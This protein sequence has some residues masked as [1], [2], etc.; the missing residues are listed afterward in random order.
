MLGETGKV[1]A[2][3][4]GGRKSAT[5]ARSFAHRM[6]RVTA[7]TIM[8]VGI[9]A[10]SS[11]PVAA[12]AA[13]VPTKPASAANASSPKPATSKPSG[14]GIKPTEVV[15]GR[16]VE[17]AATGQPLVIKRTEA[18]IAH[19]KAFDAATAQIRAI[20]VSTE[21]GALIKA[22]IKSIDD[23]ELSNLPDTVAQIRDPAAKKLVEWYRLR[24]GWGQ[25]AEYQPFL[26]AN[27]AWPDRNILNQ[28]LEEL[29]FSEGGSAASIKARFE[30]SEPRT[31][32]GHAALA[33]ADLA[34]GETSNARN[35]AVRVWRDMTVPAGFEIPFLERFGGVLTEAD[36]QWRLDRLLVDDIRAAKDRA[37]RIPAIRRQ[38][39]RLKDEDARR[40]AEARLLVFNKA[41]IDDAKF[42][43]RKALE[44]APKSDYGFLY[45]RIQLLRRQD[46]FDDAIK[47]I[48]RAP[49]DP[50][51]V[52]NLDD[53]W[54]E[55]RIL[56]YSALND[57]N[58]KLAYALVKDAGP[59]SVNPAK[60][61]AFMAGWLA[62]R[63]LNDRKAAKGHFEAAL[64]AA[65]G[66]L[67][68]GRAGY[69]LGR[70]AESEGGMPAASE[71]YQRAAKEIDTFYGQLSRLKLEPQNRRI[72]IKLPAPPTPEQIA[73]FNGLDAVRAIQI[74][75]K[76]GLDAVVIRS[77]LTH[78]RTYLQTDTE[79]AMVNHLAVAAGDV[80]MAL[81]NAKSGIARGQNMLLYSYPL[82]TFPT[83]R[84]LGKIPETA[85]L[86]AV[87]RQETEFN[88]NTVSV[89]GAKGLMQVMTITA[90]H[91]CKDYKITCELDRLLPDAAYNAT[92]ASSYIGDRMAEFRGSY[93]LSMSGFNAGPGR[94]RQ[95]I[96]QFGDPRDPQMDP[97]DWIERIPF[98]ETREYVSKVLSNIQIYRAR[99][100]NEANAL[101]LDLDLE[102]GRG[103]VS[104]PAPATGAGS[105]PAASSDGRPD[106]G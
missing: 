53:W 70:L 102:R 56:A 27:P 92:I 43:M 16:K 21:Q 86:L 49:V 17:D 23:N 106:A 80:Q 79:I 20:E 28:R 75:R 10:L 82:H 30:G 19:Y 33:S 81:R 31:G 25:A 93:V 63:F 87:T 61:Q 100:G 88:K 74:A 34:I 104:L 64:K 76:S 40:R 62:M 77:F 78:L 8:A 95:W 24:A 35:R 3:R 44:S 4:A 15:K 5:H 51:I 101:Q 39:A 85:V 83:F 91:V 45:H 84:P 47:L 90:K 98:A 57:G 71:H 18:E 13:A 68:R 48:Q 59:L 96:R 1:D 26:A 65:D 67:S 41:D 32:V 69:W 99:L 66:P 22:A 29:T 54:S 60:E 36:H 89:A 55:R 58:A 7:S 97:V 42:E 9:S 2:K 94:T 6:T 103:S 14:L 37:E 52:A 11:A 12:Q 50:Q 46:K 73:R 72:D 38:I 105:P